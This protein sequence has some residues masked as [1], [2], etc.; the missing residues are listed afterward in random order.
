MIWFCEAKTSIQ[1]TTDKKIYYRNRKFLSFLYFW[2]YNVI[3][4]FPPCL[5]SLQ[6]FP[7]YPSLLIF[8]FMASTFIDCYC[9]CMYTYICI[10][11]IYTHITNTQ[12]S[13]FNTT[14][15]CFGSWPFGTRKPVPWGRSLLLLLALPSCLHFF[16]RLKPHGLSPIYLVMSIGTILFSSHLGSH[17]GQTLWVQL[18]TVG[19]T[20]WTANS[21]IL[22][23][24]QSFSP[25]FQK[26]SLNLRCGS[27]IADVS[28]GT[29]HFSWL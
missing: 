25:L 20:I 23:L 2:D 10:C 15:I 1:K 26:Y 11:A 6:S 7:L 18:L 13:L 8:K 14:R 3:L 22:W 4:T 16:L 12:L 5:S 17:A 19:D 24:L 21:L 27:S 28:V 9:M 29:V